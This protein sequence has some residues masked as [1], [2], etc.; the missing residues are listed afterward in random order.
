MAFWLLLAS[1]IGF[2]IGWS[3]A[4]STVANECERLG[5]FYVGTT[6]Y[7]CRAIEHE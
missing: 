5:R 3:Y 2:L 7:E 4:H 6:T 1:L